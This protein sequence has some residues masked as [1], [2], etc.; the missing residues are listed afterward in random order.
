MQ[1]TQPLPSVR[2]TLHRLGLRRHNLHWLA[3]VPILAL[4]VW[5]GLS[6]RQTQ[7]EMRTASQRS[8]RVAEL[9]DT[10]ANLNECL[11]MLAQV[12]ASTGESRWVD[13]YNEAA[14]KLDAAIGE[15]GTLATPEARAA[16]A[17]TV[18]EAHRDLDVMERQAM[19]LAVSGELG[20]ARAL[21]NG[22][23]YAYLEEVY[24]NGSNV[25]IQELTAIANK[26]A[27]DL[28]ARNWLQTAGLS[29]SAILLG[30]TALSVRGHRRLEGALA[31]TAAVARTDTL[32]ELPN[33]RHFYEE[34][35]AALEQGRRDGLDNALLLID[36]D[37]FKAAN[38][39]HG[40]PA[41][42][43]LL[44]L[45]AA[46]LR[47]VLRDEARIARLGGD[48]FAFV[49]CCDPAGP[50]K[51][52]ADPKMVADR[53]VQALCQPFSLTSGAIIQIG[54]SIGIGLTTAGD[55]T[56]DELMHRADIALYRAKADGRGCSR[57]FEPGMDVSVRARAL[58][59]GELRQAIADDA[60]VPHFQPLVDI[61]T[62]QL[63]GVEMLAR[64]PHPTHGMVPPDQFIPIAEDLGLIGTLTEQLLRRA[65]R[66]AMAWPS[67]ISLACNVSPVQ[68]RDRNLP[69]MIQGVLT[70][71]G[72]PASRIEIEVTE[73]ALVGDLDLARGLL[74][75][76]RTLGVRLALDDFGTGY[77]SLRHLQTLPF[78]KIKIDRSFVTA[79][80]EDPESAKI[81]SAVLG[82]GRSLG[83]STVAEGIESETTAA[84]LRD[85]GC[86]IGQGWLFG[87]PISAELTDALLVDQRARSE[88][89][90]LVA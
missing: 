54:A 32:T 5:L 28:D 44:R 52:K 71:T 26:R 65:C 38:D 68:L 8:V 36:L 59:E 85:L 7:Q 53:V 47:H 82:L 3:V 62:G 72:F 15:A 27:A 40:H 24:G 70:E 76:L 35:G 19:K 37:R 83:L 13:R 61:G 31:R 56:V 25:F 60:I 43:E 73:S 69:A 50:D 55:N 51:P 46:R 90:P 45:V 4:L 23:E 17:S 12:A 78:D 22:P 79:M 63:I 88:S 84:F 39:A 49:L 33:R 87:R 48:E 58:L 81:V 80:T 42:D 64:W 14:F 89:L 67:E 34:L 11:T 75:Q 29:L 74:D 2:S 30:A 1:D 21:L 10:I 16:L 18:G 86:D 41:G 77:S 9:Q 66:A 57:V 6:G 20:A